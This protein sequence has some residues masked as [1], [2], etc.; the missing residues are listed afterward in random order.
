MTNLQEKW[1]LVECDEETA[2]NYLAM[3]EMEDGLEDQVEADMTEEN[4]IYTSI[5]GPTGLEMLAF[6]QAFQKLRMD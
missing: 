5:S 2:N 4:Y 1:E 3:E 6:W